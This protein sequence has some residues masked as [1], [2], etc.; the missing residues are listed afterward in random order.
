MATHWKHKMTLMSTHNVCFCGE[1]K[2]MY[3]LSYLDLCSAYIYMYEYDGVSTCTWILLTYL[4]KDIWAFIKVH[5]SKEEP[6]GEL[7]RIAPGVGKD[8]VFIVCLSKNNYKAFKMFSKQCFKP[9]T[10]TYLITLYFIHSY[11]SV[12]NW[13]EF[14][15]SSSVL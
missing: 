11:N 3:A 1:I 6:I 9:H 2:K 8:C 5:H 12:G 7:L 4:L 15:S 13:P 10:I 14:H